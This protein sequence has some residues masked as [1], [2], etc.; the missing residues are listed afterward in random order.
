MNDI[1]IS[2]L[3]T[4]YASSE[5][6]SLF[7]PKNKYKIWRKLWLALAEAEMELGLPIQK[8]QIKEMEKHLDTIDFELVRKFEMSLKH[9]VMAHIKAFGAVC[10]MAEPIIHLGA[11]S[12]FVTDNGDLIQ[13]AEGLS[14][15]EKKL[16]KLLRIFSKFCEKYASLPCLSYTHFQAAQPTTMG[17]RGCLWLQDFFFDL[18]D[19]IFRK[20]N[21]F[22]LGVKGATGTQ[23]SL[24][25][26]FNNDTKKI[27]ELEKLVA[28]K[29][30][31]NKV[32]KIASQ[33]YPRKQ[34]VHII[35]V[36]SNIAVSAHKFAT[37]L[38]LLAHLK[39]VEEPFE[40]SQVGSSAMPYKR[41][42]VLSERICSL[43][44]FLI[45]LGEN[46]RYTAATQWLERSLDDSANRRMTMPEAFLT[47][48][49]ILELL[50][51]V[52]EN[53]ILYP[54]MIEK[55]LNEELPF[56]A[57]ETALMKGVK[58]GESRQ[59][60]H[61]KM[62]QSSLKARALQKEGEDIDLLNELS[63]SKEDLNITN[64]IGNAPH[65]VKEYLK[66]E[67]NP[68]LENYKHVE[69]ASKKLEV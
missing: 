19:L 2:P 62:R 38:R 46:P 24:L 61:E 21:L 54:K 8:S 57:I 34:D 20:E 23:A 50:L 25:T 49:A 9:D 52:T 56:M 44:R 68:F 32:L 35:E 5:C 1:Y 13:Y 69:L 60:L 17:K 4:R 7:S 16:V 47:A 10:P 33:T 31:F 51:Y 64:F 43:S 15:I 27:G 12:A 29:M 28:N 45:A 30:G 22:F 40:T 39:E 55:H 3:A 18:K 42:P 36:L 66:D 26:L 59:D 6:S 67:V 41:N 58:K 37:D 65:Q 11:T 63:L 14:L 53:L 48:D